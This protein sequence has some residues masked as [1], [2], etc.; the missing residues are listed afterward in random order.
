MG[1]VGARQDE[2]GDFVIFIVADNSFFAL[3][4]AGNLI[5]VPWWTSLYIR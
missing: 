5:L 4:D 2:S 3:V 1:V